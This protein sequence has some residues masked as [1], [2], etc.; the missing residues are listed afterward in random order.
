MSGY[1]NG[2][3]ITGRY[4]STRMALYRS[5]QR[6]EGCM[7]LPRPTRAGYVAYSI[8]LSDWRYA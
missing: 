7:I 6:W 1:I 5:R 4:R 2:Y 8:R 3:R